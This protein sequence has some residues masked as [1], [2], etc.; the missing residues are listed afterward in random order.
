MQ[1][2][3]YKNQKTSAKLLKTTHQPHSELDDNLALQDN[4]DIDTT[5]EKTT[6]L[7]NIA[8]H[9]K[10]F[11]KPDLQNIR[12]EKPKKDGLL[13]KPQYHPEHDTT[14]HHAERKIEKKDQPKAMIEKVHPKTVAGAKNIPAFKPTLPDVFVNKHTEIKLPD[15]YVAGL[16]KYD[17]D[18]YEDYFYNDENLY[19]DYMQSNSMTSYLIEKVQELH[20]W[21][22]SSGSEI[23]SNNVVGKNGNGNDF[24]QVLKALN[25][26]IVEGNITIVL[27]KLKDIYYGDNY[28]ESV[29]KTMILTN[30]TDLLSFGILTLDVMLLHNIQLMAWENQ[31][32]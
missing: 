6:D 14:V 29:S 4:N 1:E 28:T 5:I 27:D 18:V 32:R 17:A 12:T 25:D 2:S 15:G 26:S 16:R 9:R 30:R 8:D 7:K 22:G 21:I 19:E 13:I 23:G 10:E 31:V 3:D 11:K 20:D 24:N